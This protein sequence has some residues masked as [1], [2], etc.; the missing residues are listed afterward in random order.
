M[1]DLLHSCTKFLKIAPVKML[2]SLYI[3]VTS[4]FSFIF[5]KP[6]ARMPTHELVEMECSFTIHKVLV[7]L[8]ISERKMM[9]QSRK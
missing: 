8:T 5:Y 7:M 2:L 6:S 9:W 3:T 1:C 4:D